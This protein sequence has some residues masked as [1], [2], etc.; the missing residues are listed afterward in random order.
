MGLFK[1]H[2]SEPVPEAPKHEGCQ[3][4]SR[5]NA[6]PQK[7]HYGP[8]FEK[9][10]HQEEIFDRRAAGERF[11]MDHPELRDRA[12]SFHHPRQQHQYTVPYEK[13]PQPWTSLMQAEHDYYHALSDGKEAKAYTKAIGKAMNTPVGRNTVPMIEHGDKIKAG[14]I[15][16][17]EGRKLAN[18]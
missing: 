9:G 18:R 7:S 8:H 10:P 12:H 4:M 5:R 17:V 13:M 6:Q 3:P 11:P 14:I 1:R 16:A 15:P 2:H